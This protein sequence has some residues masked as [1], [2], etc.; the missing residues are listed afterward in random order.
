M[1]SAVIDEDKLAEFYVGDLMEWK[2]AFTRSGFKQGDP[3]EL[4]HHGLLARPYTS[5]EARNFT[6]FRVSVWC[7]TEDAQETQSIK[8]FDSHRRADAQL[9]ARGGTSLLISLVVAFGYE[10]KPPTTDKAGTF[11][12]AKGM[13]P[14][15]FT[16]SVERDQALRRFH[17]NVLR[18]NEFLSTF[19]FHNAYSLFYWCRN[20]MVARSGGEEFDQME[21]HFQMAKD[22]KAL[23][24]ED[25]ANKLAKGKRM[26]LAEIAADKAA[27]LPTVS[28]TRYKRRRR[29]LFRIKN[30][31]A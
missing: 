25:N 21:E 23:D 19:E 6:H 27:K 14:Q 16:R 13:T 5:P 24:L 28:S 8:N 31:N 12:R 4:V 17:R 9:L 22:R 3:D 1:C 15:C 26:L 30:P 10:L 11:R 29:K 20:I 7:P 2:A 18:F